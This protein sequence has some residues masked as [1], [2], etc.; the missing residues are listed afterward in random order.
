[1]LATNID[2]IISK[3]EILFP[4]VLVLTL[5]ACQPVANTN[6]N[7][8]VNA[9]TQPA[10]SN[11]SS[12]SS[13]GT[14]INAR[15]PEKYSATLVFTI[16]TEGREKAIGIPPLSVQ[17]ARN[18]VDRR[19]EFKLPDGTPLI[20]L[21]HDNRQYVIAPGRKQYAELSKEAT[22]VQLQKLMTPGQIVADLKEKQ[23][24]E[25][26]GEE[27]VNGRMAEKYRYSAST[28]TSTK[29]G[30]VKAEAF[31]F[32]DKE[33]GLPLRTELNA[34]S[35]GDVKG[36]N[37]ARLVAEMRD[38]KTD[39]DVSMFEIPAGYSQVAPEKVRQQI[40]ALTNAVAAVLRAMMA[41]MRIE[42]G[43]SPSPA[44][45]GSPK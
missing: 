12:S 43:A 3:F 20:Y 6:S 17:V 40:D 34:Q 13:S 7:S 38:I 5:N 25:R 30:E 28:N 45:T 10:N 23:G 16:E 27:Q 33:T 36:V 2:R 39:P 22:G 1:M 26:A 9:N 37:A 4:L 29:V 14:A 19:V 41:N 42:G 8:N 32:I 24:V 15:E 44:V 35:S 21:D 31:V 18:G 11:A